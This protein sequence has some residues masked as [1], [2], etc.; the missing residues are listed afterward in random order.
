M[1]RGHAGDS[2]LILV[3]VVYQSARAR[4]A[5]I[6][7]FLSAHC[8]GTIENRCRWYRG[9]ALDSLGWA[10]GDPRGAPVVWVARGT[11]ASYPSRQSCDQGFW[12][13]DTCDANEVRLRYPVLTPAQNAGSRGHPFGGRADADGCIA[14]PAPPTAPP[15]PLPASRPAASAS[16]RSMVPL[17]AGAHPT[18]T[19]PPPTA[20]TSATTRGSE[21]LLACG[22]Q[23]G[24]RTRGRAPKTSGL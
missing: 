14:P 23:R 2:E 11:H 3:D 16:G 17:P 19:S 21:P 20:A 22:R 8:H 4:W 13:Y 9:P 5:A 24:R 6:G 12:N 7:V 10:G 15:P 1:C 18:A